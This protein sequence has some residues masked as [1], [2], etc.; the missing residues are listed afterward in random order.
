VPVLVPVPV[1]VLVPVPVPVLVPVLVLALCLSLA[2]CSRGHAN[3][4]SRRDADDAV[5]K[6]QTDVKDA[7]LWVDGHF[8][9]PIGGLRGGIAVEPGKHRLELRHD[10]YW[11]HYEELDLAPRQE[12][13]LVVELAP[14]LP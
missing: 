1:P 5:V 11:S 2:A 6:I 12:L 14:V 3:D 7:S 8:I 9:G 4:P 10:A 13:S